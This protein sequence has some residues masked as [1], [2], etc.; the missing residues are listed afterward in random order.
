LLVFG[1]S[2]PQK[3]FSAR[4]LNTEKDSET[5]LLSE[6][7]LWRNFESNKQKE[8]DIIHGLYVKESQTEHKIQQVIIR[9]EIKV[10]LFKSFQFENIAQNRTGQDR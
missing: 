1:S 2:S 8:L 9:M 5:N 3:T 10:C 4:Q 6:N 7:T